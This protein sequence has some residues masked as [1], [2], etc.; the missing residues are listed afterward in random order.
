MGSIYTSQSTTRSGNWP[1][2]STFLSPVTANPASAVF[3]PSDILNE[4]GG[5]DLQLALRGLDHALG[6]PCDNM[7]TPG[8]F[9]FTG[10]LERFPKLRLAIL[11]SNAGWLPFWLGRMDD[12]THG[13]NSVMGKSEKLRLHPSD[14]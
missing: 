2:S 6:F 8:H 10:I 14:Y 7:T 1:A 11:E 4:N 9:I 12:H 13:R 3:I 5:E